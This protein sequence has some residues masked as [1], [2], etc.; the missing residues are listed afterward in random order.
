PM[1]S[2]RT[3]LPWVRR[4][5]G[6]SPHIHPW[7]FYVQRLCFFKEARGPIWTEGLIVALAIIGAWCGL[8]RT[9]LGA[10]DA[11]FARFIT[12]YT[13][14]LTTAYSLIAYKTPWCLLGFL[15]PLILLAGIG[16]AA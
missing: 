7:Y 9:H 10:A 1:D 3:Y 6:D 2:L 16:A 11:S 12:F 13:A 4:A 5:G 15:Q 8:S 14:L